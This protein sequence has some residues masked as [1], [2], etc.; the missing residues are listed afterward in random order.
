MNRHHWDLAWAARFIAP[1]EGCELHAYQDSGGIWTIGFGHTKNAHP[2]MV[3]SQAQADAFL[4]RDLRNFATEVDRLVTRKMS[5][6]QRI[7]FISLAFN[8]GASAFA[9]STALR[10]FNDGDVKGAAAALLW[11]DKDANGTVLLGLE[12]RRQAEKWLLLHNGRKRRKV[13][14]T[15]ARSKAH[16]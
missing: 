2:G 10:R 16:R 9:S 7:A 13:P 1:F 11:W 4:K 3:I 8:I 5:V 14:R 15:P 12:R 6:R